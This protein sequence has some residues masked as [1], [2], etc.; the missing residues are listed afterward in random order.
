VYIPTRSPSGYI[1]PVAKAEDHRPAPINALHLGQCSPDLHA[2][3]LAR[4]RDGAGA[5][6]RVQ[7]E[8]FDF[9]AALRTRRQD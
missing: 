4:P 9:A 7:S 5:G 2:Q 8:A 1:H 6:D 3:L